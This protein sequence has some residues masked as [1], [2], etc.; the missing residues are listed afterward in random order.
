MVQYKRNALLTF[1]SHKLIET[2]EPGGCKTV[3]GQA[4]EPQPQDYCSLM[5][6]K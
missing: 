5:G 6:V 3:E 1:Y 4:W 2:T